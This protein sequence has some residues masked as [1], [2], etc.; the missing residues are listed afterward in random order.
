[1]IMKS[2]MTILQKTALPDGREAHL[3]ATEGGFPMPFYVATANMNVSRRRRY[4]SG[5]GGYFRTREE[6]ERAFEALV[7]FRSRF[8]A[9]RAAT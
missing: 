4:N 7:T 3:I 9:E 5:R 2:R 1:M 6:A 8:V